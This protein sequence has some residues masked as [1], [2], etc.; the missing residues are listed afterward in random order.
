MSSNLSRTERIQLAQAIFDT[1]YTNYNPT[2]GQLP[3]KSIQR[4]QVRLP[5]VYV[6]LG[7]GQNANLLSA[8]AIHDL[9]TSSNTNYNMTHDHFSR[10]RTR[11]I[12][13]P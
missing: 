4:V 3:G 10:I 5:N 11:L 12:P 6:G 9:I 13:S 8:M 1:L 2:D 7:F